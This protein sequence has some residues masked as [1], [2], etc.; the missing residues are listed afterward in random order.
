MAS[1]A[2]IDRLRVATML[3]TASMLAACTGPCPTTDIGWAARYSD[4][5]LGIGTKEQENRW[6]PNPRLDS[7]LRRSIQS[8]GLRALSGRRGFQCIVRPTAENCTDC[9]VCTGTIVAEALF[10]A[11][12]FG[13]CGSDG[14]I[15]IRAAVG[16][17]DA[18]TSMTY[19]TPLE[20][21]RKS[22]E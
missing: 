19:W 6:L 3:A 9:Y 11:E 22:G 18:V 1:T 7:F 10:F 13:Y 2:R 14:T 20:R 12:P 17:G 16:P 21:K 5:A 8:D 4:D 15:A